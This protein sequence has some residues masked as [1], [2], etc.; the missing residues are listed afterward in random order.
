MTENRSELPGDEGGNGEGQEVEITKEHQE[1][2]LDDAYVYFL[3]YDDGF[4]AT[5][6]GHNLANC[7]F[8]IHA[9][10]YTLINLL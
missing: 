4:M 10:Y 6:I 9:V 8:Y 7:P 3:D 1:T 5:F 2:L